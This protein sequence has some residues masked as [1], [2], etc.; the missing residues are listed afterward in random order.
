LQVL[1]RERNEEYEVLQFNEEFSS[2]GYEL[3]LCLE[4]KERMHLEQEKNII[5]EQRFRVDESK[6]MRLEEDKL[7]QIAELKKRRHEFRNSTH[8]YIKKVNT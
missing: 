2:L 5:E 3:R 7:L 6:R 4:D 8:V 1:A